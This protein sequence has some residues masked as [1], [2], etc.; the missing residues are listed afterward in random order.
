MT[1]HRKKKRN[2]GAKETS[3]RVV[4][5]AAVRKTNGKSKIEDWQFGQLRYRDD[6]DCYW[7]RVEWKP[8]L[9]IELFIEIDGGEPTTVI[10]RARNI[11]NARR[12]REA[13]FLDLAAEKLLDSFNERLNDAGEKP[14]D[15]RSF[16]TRLGLRS[17]VIQADGESALEYVS[18]AYVPIYVIVSPAL[19]FKD[20]L[21]C[22]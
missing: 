7:G 20:A 12:D 19:E 15:I 17:L 22:I 6:V 2:A 14:T 10:E 3:Q 21:F 18:D 9:K 8:K 4:K 5:L 1:T 11:F 16:N 13:E